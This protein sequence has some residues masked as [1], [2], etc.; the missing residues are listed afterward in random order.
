MPISLVVNGIKQKIE[1]NPWETLLDVLR[2]RLRL[3][4]AKIG[5]DTGGCGCCTVLMEEQPVY[6]CMVFASSLDGREITSIEGLAKES[7]IDPLQEA[8]LKMGAIQCGYCT[9][10][11]IM[12]AKAL[13]LAKR[14]PNEDEIRKALSG[15]LC[16]CTGYQKI[17]EAI[18]T[19]VPLHDG[20][21]PITE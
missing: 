10:G 11:M 3:T 21:N 1:V 19:A 4:G 7:Q 17:I 20:K 2:E 13:L 18:L 16:R 12:S 14:S 15:N 5:C 6:S 8:F 9:S